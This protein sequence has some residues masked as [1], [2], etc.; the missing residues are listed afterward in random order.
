MKSLK[1]AA[2]VAGSM[3]IVG[4]AAPAFANDA[5]DFTATSLNGGL[6]TVTSRAGQDLLDVQPLHTDMLDT[7]NKNSL[8]GAGQH[9]VDNANEVGLPGGLLGGLPLQK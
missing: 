9:A 3:V 7:E 1:A 2:V 8:V 4:V 6:D 5:S